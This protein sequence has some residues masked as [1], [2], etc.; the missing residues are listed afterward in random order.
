M[1]QLL[2]LALT[3]LMTGVVGGESV[4]KVGT[5]VH[6]LTHQWTT[7]LG[8]DQWQIYCK[9]TIDDCEPKEILVDDRE[10]RLPGTSVEVWVDKAWRSQWSH[11]SDVRK[12]TFEWRTW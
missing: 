12:L 7:I 4:H 8:T 10:A 9:Y 5:N 11:G 1:K 6:I 2:A 3:L